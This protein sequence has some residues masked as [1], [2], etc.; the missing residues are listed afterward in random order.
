VEDTLQQECFLEAKER[1]ESRSFGAAP[2]PP[3]AVATLPMRHNTPRLPAISEQMEAF[4][5]ALRTGRYGPWPA[6]P[7]CDGAGFAVTT[8]RDGNNGDCEFIRLGAGAWLTSG[9]MRLARPLAIWYRNRGGIALDIAVRGGWQLGYLHASGNLVTVAS[10]YGSLSVLGQDSICGCLPFVGIPIEFVSLQFRDESA[11]RAFGLKPTELAQVLGELAVRQAARSHTY[12]IEPS[13]DMRGAARAVRQ[14]QF[15]GV[16]RLLYMKAK[17]YELLANLSAC[18]QVP[19]PGPESHIGP[20]A[21]DASLAAL[22]VSAMG[23]C[24]ERID[25]QSLARQFDVTENRLLRAF[26]TTYGTT[27]FGYANRARVARGREMLLEGNTS[28]IDIA[29]T[30]GYEHHSS[31]TTAYRRT[32]G[33]TPRETRLLARRISNQRADSRAARSAFNGIHAIGQLA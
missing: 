22:A 33:E 24:T 21:D 15:S 29:F 13:S 30:C 16:S 20:A 3:P 17:A 4:E 27:P 19:N 10:G 12:V 32:Y 14:A 1:P 5:A 31:F 28:L 7:I 23:D 25:A 6:R 18:R 2:S 26:K 11:M 8:S 9:T